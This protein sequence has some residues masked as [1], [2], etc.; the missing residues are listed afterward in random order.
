M[1]ILVQEN[2]EKEKNKSFRYSPCPP[3]AYYL[4][5]EEHRIK[6]QATAELDDTQLRVKRMW[7][8]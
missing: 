5:K 1:L 7:E 4:T 8:E 3:G 6:N 2:A